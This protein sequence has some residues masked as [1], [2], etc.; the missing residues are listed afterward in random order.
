[1]PASEAGIPKTS[2]ATSTAVAAPAMAHQCGFTRNPA[3]RPNS[4]RIGSAATRVEKTQ[5]CSGSYTWVHVMAQSPGSLERV[6]RS[7]FCL[8]VKPGRISPV[9]PPTT[10]LAPG[11]RHRGCAQRSTVGAPHAPPPPPRRREPGP[12]RV[13]CECRAGGKQVGVK[14]A[15]PG[16]APARDLAVVV[17]VVGRGIHAGERLQVD[18]PQRL[19]PQERAGAAQGV[20]ARAD[21]L[22]AAVHRFPLAHG[23][24]Q[25]A[26][27]LNGDGD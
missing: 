12:A 5:L 15:E 22:T 2:T 23:T 4:T 13:E 11:R 17:D 18:D 26:E 6:K 3:S 25:G 16:V 9:A 1:M 24:A 8:A 14:V 27:I 20:A 10:R 19:L 7:A 21:D